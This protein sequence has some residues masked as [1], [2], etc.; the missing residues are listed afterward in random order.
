MSNP[1][2]NATTLRLSL[3]SAEPAS[4]DSRLTISVREAA[5]WLGISQGLAW[6]LVHAGQIPS[7]HLGRR[8]LV[9][10]AGLAETVRRLTQGALEREP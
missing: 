9:P 1:V 8:V 6:S 5:T 7:F 2:A 10:R 3:G 4:P